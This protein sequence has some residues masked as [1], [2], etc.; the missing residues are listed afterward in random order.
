MDHDEDGKPLTSDEKAAA[1]ESFVRKARGV[2]WSF[3]NHGITDVMSTT[4]SVLIDKCGFQVLRAAHYFLLESKRVSAYEMLIAV[5]TID[6]VRYP[7]HKPVFAIW[8]D[9]G[10]EP[11]ED[12]AIKY[13]CS[14]IGLNTM[15]ALGDLKERVNCLATALRCVDYKK[16]KDPK[17]FN[18]LLILVPE[19]SKPTTNTNW[20]FVIEQPLV[21]KPVTPG[22]KALFQKRALE[23]S[24][25]MTG[26]L[27]SGLAAAKK[28][29]TFDVKAAKFVVPKE[30]MDRAEA[31]VAALIAE[32]EKGAADV[33]RAVAVATASNPGKGKK[34][35]VK[36][37]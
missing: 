33:A 6:R 30:D 24:R 2:A 29:D 28:G 5:Q 18:V 4:Q 20:Q 10:H 36:K 27:L 15:Q 14:K 9:V 21:L 7:L 17:C 23:Q 3:N 11:T 19:G 26:R 8:V 35:Y 31:M 13:G 25:L 12:D 37:R 34:K 22:L 32:D 1:F 16:N